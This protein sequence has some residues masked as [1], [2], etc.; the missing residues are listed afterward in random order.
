MLPITS[1]VEVPRV[2]Q[3]IAKEFGAL[4]LREFL[5]PDPQATPADPAFQERLRQQLWTSLQQHDG[6]DRDDRLD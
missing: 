4:E 6:R 3:E 5:A 2:P 1:V